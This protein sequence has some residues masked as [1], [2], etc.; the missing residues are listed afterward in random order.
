MSVDQKV[1]QHYTHG[2]LL[3]AVDESLRALG[4]DPARLQ[5]GDLAQ[6]DELHIGG[7]EA[8]VGFISA[9]GF[10]SSMRILDVGSGLGGP[11]RAFAR[12]TGAHVTGIDLTPEFVGVAQTL[13]E[14]VG[15]TERTSFQQG[16]ALE[17]PFAAAS[18]DG[19]YMIHVGMNIEA[20]RQLFK[21]VRRVLRAGATFGVYD[22]MQLAPGALRFPLPWSTQPDTSFVV[23][24]AT[25]HAALAEAGFEITAE[26]DKLAFARAF[27]DQVA[28]QQAKGPAPPQAHRG[29]DFPRKAR[30]LR[31][32]VTAG[33][34]GPC[35]IIA[36]A[37]P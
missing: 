1:Q 35:E 27:F 26:R 37:R 14:R 19:A 6:V 34:L 18:F 33:I 11:A 29:A 10:T 13:S 5:P 16:S 23:D 24:P 4:K 30:N 22:I 9:C 12:T 17:L 2:S 20:K 28:A 32:L 7:H 8:T 21:E 3:A 25:Y 36:R 31:D 15:L